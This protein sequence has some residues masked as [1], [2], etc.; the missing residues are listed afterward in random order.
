[1]DDRWLG[2]YLLGCALVLFLESVWRQDGLTAVSALL[3]A[4]PGLMLLRRAR[5]RGRQ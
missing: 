3:L 1:M 2:Y 4:L 5:A